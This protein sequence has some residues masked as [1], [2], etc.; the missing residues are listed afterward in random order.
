MFFLPIS[1]FGQGSVEMEFSDS[2]SSAPVSARMSFTKSPKKVIR[3]RK[4]LQAGEQWL[5]E[6]KFPLSLPNGE[7]EFL[8]ERGPEF[9]VIRGGF[10]MESKAKDVVTVAVPRSVDMHAEGWY[11]GDHL[12]TLP[13]S[14]LKRWQ[15]GDALDLAI[16]VAQNQPASEVTQ[17]K[18]PI[19]PATSNIEDIGLQLTLNSQR[20]E[21]QQGALLLHSDPPRHTNPPHQDDF[22]EQPDAQGPT[23]PELSPSKTDTAQVLQHLSKT[24]EHGHWIE[25]LN[26]WQR[27]TPF[28]L[29]TDQVRAVQILSEGN[30]PGSDVQ[31]AFPKSNAGKFLE[32]KV[33]ILRGKERSFLSLFAPI[34]ADDEIRF[35]NARGLGSLSEFL[36]WQML[37]AGFRIAPTAGSCFDANETIL[38]Y[39]RVYVFTDAPPTPTTW[40][41]NIQQ[42]RTTVT[43]GPLL[44]TLVNGQPPGSVLASYRGQSI[45]VDIAVSLTVREPV[46]YL[47]VVFNGKTIYSAKLEDHYK[48]GEFPPIEIEESGWMV[49]RVVT[50]HDKGYRLATTA[51]FYFEFDNQP[52]KS[53]AAVAFFATWLSRSIDAF[54]KD[55][56]QN[57]SM[58]PFLE[59]TKRF[60]S[61]QLATCTAD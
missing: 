55:K 43:N 41:Q 25:L 1:L 37:E 30:R 24:K 27:D 23:T 17:P 5:A 20:I 8:A 32:G 54:K 26:P 11:S 10:T 2:D 15:A 21:W 35:H 16:S 36:H 49:I 28:L 46:D 3:P 50:G 22:Y 56:D 12:S 52:R 29:A 45:S 58:E 9:K 7:Y 19:A 59:P 40:M 47:D 38:G 51:P 48:K 18:R 42:G 34:P 53:K 31:I 39:N 44:R 33:P 6:E 61:E 57:E 14:V 60:W 13:P 4:L